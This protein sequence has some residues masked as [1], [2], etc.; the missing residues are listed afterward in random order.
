MGKY[1]EYLIC[2]VR[3]HNPDPL[4]G[5]TMNAVFNAVPRYVCVH[6]GTDFWTTTETIEHEANAP[7]P[8]EEKSK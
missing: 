4:R 6:C 2:K 5:A 1:E 7:K 3:G 8:L